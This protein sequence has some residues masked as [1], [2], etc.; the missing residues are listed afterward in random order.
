M[1]T[2]GSHEKLR[3]IREDG[4]LEAQTVPL[5]K[6]LAIR[7]VGAIYRQAARFIPESKL[8]SYVFTE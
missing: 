6:E 4:I 8:G 7:T 2:C 5:R 3:R 1:S